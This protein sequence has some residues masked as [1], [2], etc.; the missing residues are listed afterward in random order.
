[1]FFLEDCCQ[2]QKLFCFWQHPNQCFFSVSKQ[3]EAETNSETET[4]SGRMAV[5]APQATETIA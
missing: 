5:P 3:S 4:E 1:L 2:K